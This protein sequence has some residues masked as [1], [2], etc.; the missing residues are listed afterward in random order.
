MRMLCVF[1]AWVGCI[2]SSLSQIYSFEDE[3]I[4]GNFTVQSGLLNVSDIKSKLGSKSLC[5]EWNRNS[6]LKMN[7]PDGL[8]EASISTS[9]GINLWIYNTTSI[10]KSLNFI[11]SNASGLKKCSFSFNLNFQGW[12]CLWARFTED[13]GHDN[14]PLGLMEIKAPDTGSG[15]IFLDYL[16]F[17]TNVSWTKNS[18]MQYNVIQNSQIPDFFNARLKCNF[19]PETSVTNEQITAINTI[20]ARIENW[21][22]CGTGIYNYRSEYVDRMMAIKTWIGRAKNY[23][24]TNI[25]LVRES[26]GTVKGEG[27]FPEF[28]SNTISGVK[29][30]RFRDVSESC[31]L[32]FALD[33]RLYNN[34]D[35][36]QKYIDLID[37]YND[38]GWADGSGLGS[39]RFEKLRSCGYFH[40]L[41]LMRNELGT[42]RFQRELNTLTWFSLLGNV[43]DNFST[44]GELADNIRTLAIAKLYCALMQTDN[45]KRVAA[46]KA[47]Q[48]YFNN[49]FDTAPGYLGTF[50]PD[51]S[52]YHHMGTYFGAYYPDAL[53]AASL[54]TYLLHD[55]SFALSDHIFDV[56]KNQLLVLRKTASVYDVPVAT[57][58]RFPN[59]TTAVDQLVPAFAYL[60]FSKK[61]PDVELLSA[62]ARLWHPGQQPLKGQISKATTDICLKTTPGEIALCLK[63]IDLNVNPENEPQTSFYL[64]YSGLLINRNNNHHVSIK[65]FSKYIWDYEASVTENTY[66]RYLSYGQIEYTSMKTGRRNNAYNSLDWNWNLIPGTTVKYLS[67]QALGYTNGF[68]YR[69]FSDQPFL[70]GV[71]SNDSVSLFSMKLHDNAFDKSFYA[72]KSVFCFGD[73]LLCLGSNI[74]NSA[75]SVPTVTTLF[76]QLPKIGE[77]IVLNGSPLMSSLNGIS[78]PVI[79]DNLGIHYIVNN[80]NVNIVRNGQIYSAYITHG[81][82]PQHQKYNYFMLLNADEGMKEKYAD[83]HLN[84]VKI[85]RQDEVA[86]IVAQNELKT[87]AYAIFDSSVSLN[88]A[89]IS[90]VN[91]PSLLILQQ[92]TDTNTKLVISDPDLRRPSANS[93]DG[94]VSSDLAVESSP[95]SYFVELNG[96]FTVESAD[97]DAETENTA[98]TTRI[99]FN[100]TQGKMYHFLLKKI[101]SDVNNPYAEK[102]YSVSYQKN[103]I[104]ISTFG[105]EPFG[106]KLYCVDGKKVIADMIN[107][108]SC[109]IR[110]DDFAKGAY[111]MELLC[112]NQSV[113]KKLILW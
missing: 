43:F 4:P 74:T 108:S 57:C 90:K 110:V 31:L 61:N 112:N 47:L 86:H 106:V 49:A 23:F 52:G 69:N 75:S 62:F 100:V 45:N 104:I 78:N 65:G 94:L 63:A 3:Q 42:K 56:L 36:K 13:M 46:L 12:R 6:T 98:T 53:Y 97:I 9:G 34:A 59:G 5:W 91:T 17:P 48:Q 25:S 37:W 1:V 107:Q 99:K 89:F 14:S 64:P 71:V 55:T 76:Q 95:F 30:K 40:S 84:P 60:A 16:Q 38:Q 24:S 27:L 88:D 83:P 20:S 29:I 18:D 102:R 113:R 2:F 67:K 22:L 72:N 54:M 15:T 41:Y 33:Y 92:L 51:F 93:I 66:G 77:Q 26:D 81:F 50:K 32:Q 44:P 11:F 79:T 96:I 80:G 87:R 19:A 8:T 7:F 10:D 109:T 58:G 111:V 35:S 105:R 103:A 39:L 82:A 68:P 73:V 101:Q 28:T 21:L 70:G 85:I